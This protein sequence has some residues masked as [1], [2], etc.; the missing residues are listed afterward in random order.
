MLTGEFAGR[1]R[2]RRLPGRSILD[3]NSAGPEAGLEVSE[4]ALLPF[5][6]A[7]R[8]VVCMPESRPVFAEG[9]ASSYETFLYTRD[10]TEALDTDA[11]ELD[12]VDLS[13]AAEWYLMQLQR[14]LPARIH[15]ASAQHPK[16]RATAE[17]VLA[18]WRQ[19]EKVVVFCHFIQTGR[20]LRRVISDRIHE[21]IC[22]IGGEKLRCS[23]KRAAILLQR[24]SRR[25]FDM[26]SPV[27]RACDE[28]ISTLL[29][30]YPRLARQASVHGVS[31]PD[32][33]RR[34]VR[35]PS[36]LVRF[37]PLSRRG[38]KPGAIR[39][40][41][42]GDTGLHDV[43]RTFLE[44]L[45]EQCTP[46]ECDNYI[47]A[48]TRIQTGDMTGREARSSFETDELAGR[49]RG[50]LLLPNVRLVNGATLHETRQR[51]M[52]TF[53]SPF[54]LKYSSAATC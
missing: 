35:T 53:N 3:G 18:A 23:P 14:A 21:E 42:R 47:E 41:F 30:E 49:K 28:E 5:L 51:L 24:I 48:V 50:D 8:A 2:R 9:L 4:G 12:S 37:L 52:L 46:E 31:L 33:I 36:F 16:V 44:F 34:Y 25:F 54:S 15:E 11:E 32:T 20:T 1:P 10:P 22:R 43:L 7:A 19:N 40:A 17:R 26:D 27:R 13:Q 39:R 29:R 45:Q 6:L 38:L